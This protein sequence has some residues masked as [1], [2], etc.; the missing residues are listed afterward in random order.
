MRPAHLEPMNPFAASVLVFIRRHRCVAL[1]LIAACS[2]ATSAAADSVDDLLLSL[3]VP[4]MT[5]IQTP[6]APV[7]DGKVAENEWRYA[8]S[9]AGFLNLAD[10]NLADEKTTAQVMFD[11]G[12]L[13]FAFQCVLASERAPQVA[14][15][16]RDGGVNSDESIEVHLLPPGADEKDFIHLVFNSRG[17]IF[18]R[19][20]SDVK[21][22]GHW[23]IAN[24]SGMGYWNAEVAVPL[25]DL[26]V[27]GLA[28]Q[29]W[30]INFARSA[31]VHTSWSYTGKGYL[32]P[33]RWGEVRFVESGAVP[34]VS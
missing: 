32:N 20:G 25:A 34:K 19:R 31:G 23:Q 7:I 2:E 12:N 30:R 29:T 6:R 17:T 10:G 15:I 9:T 1:A 22:D 26:G 18:D 4:M 3:P 14:E 16:K 11:S 5:V 24:E 33:P 27:T 28:G 13:Y 8:A 21:W